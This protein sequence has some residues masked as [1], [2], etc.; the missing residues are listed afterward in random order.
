MI[1]V[2]AEKPTGSDL[3]VGFLVF[4]SLIIFIFVAFLLIAIL[5]E[6][7]STRFCV[8]IKT[9]NNKRRFVLNL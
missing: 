9:H 5:E 1:N 2:H 7:I 8:S 4:D 6:G 3:P